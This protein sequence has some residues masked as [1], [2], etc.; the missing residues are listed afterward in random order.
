M[1]QIMTW[2]NVEQLWGKAHFVGVSRPGHQLTDFGLADEVSLMQIPA[3]AISSTD[4]RKRV[5]AGKPVWY[6][7]PDGVVQYIGKYGLYI[8]PNSKSNR[9]N[10][11]PRVPVSLN[12]RP[13]EADE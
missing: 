12:N 4:C 2:K 1:E 10:T 5:A 11:E 8:D 7:V 6:L 3:M 13:E 9:Q